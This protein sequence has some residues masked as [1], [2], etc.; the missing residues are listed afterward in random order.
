LGS[1]IGCT[2]GDCASRKDERRRRLANEN[3]LNIAAEFITERSI[4]S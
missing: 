4:S 2:D 3:T 1:V